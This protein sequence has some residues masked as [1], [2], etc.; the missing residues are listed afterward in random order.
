M[1]APRAVCHGSRLAACGQVVFPQLT[2]RLD[3]ERAKVA[4][5]RRCDQ[6]QIARCCNRPSHVGGTEF[7]CRGEPRSDAFGRAERHLPH[8]AVA[9]QIDTDKAAPG[10]GR[11][12]QSPGRQ[13]SLTTHGVGS[14]RLPREFRTG[15]VAGAGVPFQAFRRDQRDDHWQVIH[16]GNHPLPLL[17]E[18]DATPV[19][20]AYVARSQDRAAG[21]R[22]SED[23]LVAMRC[24]HVTA[25]AAI[26]E[27]DAPR[28]P[29][30]Q[31]SLGDERGDRGERLRR[32]GLLAHH[33]AA[34]YRPLRDREQRLAFRA[35]KDIQHARL[36]RLNDRRHRDPLHFDVPQHRLR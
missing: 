28:V 24:D 31:W 19:H 36:R 27:R 33:Q 17:I 9:T 12:R 22:R 18:D 30:C 10:R 8:D 16:G 1:I 2:A 32:P 20:T 26:P 23:A 4:V 34:R 13:Q 21:V 7:A 5:H 11:A 14:A 6:H 35:L 25:L 29:R 3:I 15:K